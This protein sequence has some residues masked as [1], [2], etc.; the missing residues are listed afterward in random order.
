MGHGIT[1]GT[2]ASPAWTLTSL[3][4]GTLVA[5][6]HGWMPVPTF[7]CNPKVCTRGNHTICSMNPVNRLSRVDGESYKS[8]L[9][10]LPRNVCFLNGVSLLRGNPCV[11]PSWSFYHIPPPLVPSLFHLLSSQSCLCPFA[12]ELASAY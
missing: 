2:A 11:H 8:S 7:H 1:G 5:S 4:N 3:F 6:P 10:V 12:G 9:K